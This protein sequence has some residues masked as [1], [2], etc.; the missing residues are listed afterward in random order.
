MKESSVLSDVRIDTL[1]ARC[2][3][4]RPS[5]LVEK[6]KQIRMEGRKESETRATGCDRCVGSRAP[7]AYHKDDL[8][9]QGVT[10]RSDKALEVLLSSTPRK[11]VVIFSARALARP[12]V[13]GGALFPRPT[14]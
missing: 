2:L 13:A 14:P 6:K 9:E 3:R 8:M 10:D 11:P 5:N 12:R 4:Y 7:V 1:G